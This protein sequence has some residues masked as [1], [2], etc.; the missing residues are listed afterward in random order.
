MDSLVLLNGLVNACVYVIL[1]RHTRRTLLR[2]PGIANPSVQ[3]AC[4]ERTERP[5]A[6]LSFNVVIRSS[7]ADFRLVPAIYHEA[8]ANSIQDARALPDL[9]TIADL[10]DCLDDEEEEENE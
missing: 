2:Q 1:D 3:H 8:R 5:D 4:H 9:E 10:L 6:E 7:S